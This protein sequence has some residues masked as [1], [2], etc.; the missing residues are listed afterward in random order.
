MSWVSIFTMMLVFAVSGVIFRA[1][2]VLQPHCMSLAVGTSLSVG[3]FMLGWSL[4]KYIYFSLGGLMLMLLTLQIP[5]ALMVNPWKVDW[6]P[7]LG[8]LF[9]LVWLCGVYVYAIDRGINRYVREKTLMRLKAEE[10][11]GIGKL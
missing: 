3:L 10:T 5:I 6:L 4:R 8:G 11:K 7:G 1:I 2:P 9:L